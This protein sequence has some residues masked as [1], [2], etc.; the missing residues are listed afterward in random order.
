MNKD[1][2]VSSILLILMTLLLWWGFMADPFQSAT[3]PLTLALISTFAGWILFRKQRSPEPLL[4]S[5]SGSLVA[6]AI[7]WSW[8]Y[9]NI[10]NTQSLT[11]DVFRG[12]YTYHWSPLYAKPHE[13]GANWWIGASMIVGVC[14][15]LSIYHW[16]RRLVPL[17]SLILIG[18]GILLLIPDGA[19]PPRGHFFTLTETLDTWS[20]WTLILPE[21]VSRMKDLD[22]HSSHYPPG[23]FILAWLTGPSTLWTYLINI[24]STWLIALIAIRRTSLKWT[25]GTLVLLLIPGFLLIPAI[26][27]E[28]I[29]A[30]LFFLSLLT[31]LDRE[32]SPIEK[33]IFAGMFL[34][35]GS[36]F[37]FFAFP[38]GFLLILFIFLDP[39][40]SLPRVLRTSISLGITFVG[41]WALF[42]LV[43]GYHYLDGLQM[44]ILQNRSILGQ[45]ETY[46][47]GPYFVRSTGNLLSFMVLSGPL[48]WSRSLLNGWTRSGMVYFI[49]LVLLSFSGLFFMETERIWFLAYPLLFISLKRDGP[50]EWSEVLVGCWLIL[51]ITFHGD[52]G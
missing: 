11:G 14:L 29:P 34:W 22:T 9:E 27:P 33:G 7:G 24:L 13:V 25:D 37:S 10:R 20:D 28:G 30:I 3:F 44:A 36:L 2:R 31:F 39:P 6:L 35:A 15:L 50:I 19:W 23:M 45:P 4:L 40:G 46:D 5:V 52:L 8:I 21:Y 41:L 48:L 1:N 12:V 49:W 42:Y 47:L 38:V 18:T 17:V 32:R 16:S 26:S 51:Q 43:T